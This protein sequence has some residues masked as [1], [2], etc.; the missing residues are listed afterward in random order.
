METRV[1]TG[2]L[3]AEVMVK[4]SELDVPP[5]GAGV[6][7]V[8]A[9]VP[10]EDTNAP[11]TIAV[12]CSPLTKVVASAV[13]FQLIVDEAMKLVPFTVRVNAAVP[14]A[15]LA[16]ERELAVGTGLVE[17]GSIVKT[18]IFEVPPPGVPLNTVR[19]AVPE[20]AT[21]DALI[22]AVNCV[23]LTNVVVSDAPFQFTTDP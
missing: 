21:S 10:A 1:G 8:T 18:C 16:G 11:L 23:E 9:A 2:L 22:D 3:P 5:P 19:F 20:V 13:P 17:T 12:I 7:T 14:A 6:T 4:V 15:V